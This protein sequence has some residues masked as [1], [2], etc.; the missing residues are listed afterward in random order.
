MNFI[1]RS[2]VFCFSIHITIICNE[3]P[4]VL[5]LPT[6]SSVCARKFAS[7]AMSCCVYF[8]A[9]WGLTRVFHF[10]QYSSGVVDNSGISKCLNTL[11]LLSFHLCFIIMALFATCLLPVI[12]HG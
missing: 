2:Q 10:L 3:I 1:L 6:R 5:C 9:Q 7:P 11:L 12:I 4:P 8:S